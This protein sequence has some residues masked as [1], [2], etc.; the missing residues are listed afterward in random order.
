M[1]WLEPW[2]PLVDEPEEAA[3]MER[4]LRRELA[5][6]H[7]LY[8]LLVGAIGRRG[9]CDDVLFAAE[10]GTRRV[11]VVRL[12]WQGGQRPPWPRTAWYVDIEEWQ[13]EDMRPSHEQFCA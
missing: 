10:D 8:G 12:T 5:D 4:E 3:A 6:P 9:D 1:E 2:Y 7:S 13:A 11:V